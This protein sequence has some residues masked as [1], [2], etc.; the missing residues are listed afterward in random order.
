MMKISISEIFT[1]KKRF[2]INPKKNNTENQIKMCKVKEK[3]ENQVKHKDILH[4]IATKFQNLI[5]Q[6]E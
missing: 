3:W 2:L 1:L 4:L 5:R 6:I